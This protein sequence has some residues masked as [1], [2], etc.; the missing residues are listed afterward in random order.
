MRRAIRLGLFALI[1]VLPPA[2]AARADDAEEWK[3][4]KGTWKGEK[5]VLAGKDSSDFFKAA[6]LTMDEG[7]YTVVIGK[8]EDKGTI[9]LDASKK[10]KRMT[11][12]SS[13]AAKK[14]M[15]IVAIYELSG[16]T[17]KVCYALEGKDPPEGFESKEGT[18]TLYVEYKREKK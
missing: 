17:L 8:D 12:T 5:A 14:G 11:I 16:D 15:A 4:L 13:D 7:K 2:S 10:P 9:T 18:K 1:V 3:G 6:V